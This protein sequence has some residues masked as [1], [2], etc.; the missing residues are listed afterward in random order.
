M[1]EYDLFVPLVTDDGKRVST[2]WL[3]SLKKDLCKHFGGVT[4]FPQRN[5][6]L[7]R[8]GKI[9]FRDKVVILRALSRRSRADAAFWKRLKKKIRDDLKQREVLIVERTITLV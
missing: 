6:G 9:T 2:K 8:L 3:R 1:R 5:E 4:Y 7:W